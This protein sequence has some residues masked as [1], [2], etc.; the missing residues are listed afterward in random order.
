MQGYESGSS[1][2][3]PLG[4]ALKAGI[5][6]LLVLIAPAISAILFG[7]RARRR[8]ASNG[9][10]PAVIGIVVGGFSVLTNTLGLIFGR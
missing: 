5:P 1:E 2:P 4:D 9:V 8:G 3:V 6:A 7:F 10:I